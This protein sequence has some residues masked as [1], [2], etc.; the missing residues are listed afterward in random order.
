MAEM[1]TSNGISVAARQEALFRLFSRKQCYSSFVGIF[2]GRRCDAAHGC[3]KA[4]TSPMSETMP[5]RCR[6]TAGPSG[7]RDIARARQTGSAVLRNPDHDFADVFVGLEPGAG[8]GDFVE[9]E[10]AVD[11]RAEAAV[12]ECRQQVGGKSLR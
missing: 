4:V 9:R 11:D 10:G 2:A 12:A 8:G 5:G 3:I 1:E 7:S 6:A